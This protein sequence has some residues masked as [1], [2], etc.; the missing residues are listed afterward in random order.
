[1]SPRT[2]GLTVWVIALVGVLALIGAPISN[3]ASLVGGPDQPQGGG[4]YIIEPPGGG[5]GS[6]GGSDDGGDPDDFANFLPDAPTPE[7]IGS[8]PADRV[9]PAKPK[10]DVPNWFVWIFWLGIAR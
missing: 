5:P 8:T 10:R 7:L 4:S 9:L 1:M 3:A 2:L 6:G